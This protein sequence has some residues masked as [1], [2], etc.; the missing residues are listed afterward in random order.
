[1]SK[2]TLL[3]VGGMVVAAALGVMILRYV[4]PQEQAPLQPVPSPAVSP[5][6]SFENTEQV[7]PPADSTQSVTNVSVP[8]S[9]ETETIPKPSASPKSVPA[10]TPSPSSTPSPVVT[11]EKKSTQHGFWFASMYVLSDSAF[12]MTSPSELKAAGANIVSISVPCK[13]DRSGNVAYELKMAGTNTAFLSR[14]ETLIR[15]Y[16]DAD[17]KVA[18]V[19][20]LTEVESLDQLATEPV[21]FTP[22]IDM[23]KFESMVQEVA[24]LAEKNNADYFSPLN[25]PDRKLGS[26]YVAFSQSVLPKV[27]GVYSGKVMLKGDDPTSNV[28]GYDILGIS[29]SPMTTN[30]DDYRTY[31]KQRIAKLQQMKSGEI[32]VSEFGVWSNPSSFSE[33]QKAEAYRIVLEESLGK[34]TGIFAYQPYLKENWQMKGTSILETVKDFFTNKY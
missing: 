10:V 28:A 4:S 31:V 17:M 2:K 18:V 30:M 15:R 22:G 26:R 11:P 13:I 25:E 12:A 34:I 16:K 19:M 7:S 14:I 23:S 33:S 32:W 20:E 8:P 29:L 27:K 5:S 6:T 9:Y 1:M 24:A 3:L 21:P